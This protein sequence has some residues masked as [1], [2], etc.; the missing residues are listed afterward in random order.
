MKTLVYIARISNLNYQLS[1]TVNE[2][3]KVVAVS[4]SQISKLVTKMCLKVLPVQNR[5]PVKK[6][7]IDSRDPAFFYHTTTPLQFQ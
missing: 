7:F 3:P 2:S 5:A 1:E 6:W 4:L